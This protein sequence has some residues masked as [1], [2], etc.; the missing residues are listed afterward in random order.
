MEGKDFSNMKLASQVGVRDGLTLGEKDVP[1][2]QAQQAKATQDAKAAYKANDDAAFQEAYGRQVYLAGAMEGLLRKGPNYDLLQKQGPE[3]IPPLGG[4]KPKTVRLFNGGGTSWFTPDPERAASFGT[5]SYVD[6]PYDVFEKSQSAAK[7]ESGTSAD[8]VLPN[9]WVKQ[10]QPI[11]AAPMVHDLDAEEAPVGMGAAKLGEK[12]VTV[13]GT[14]DVYGIRQATRE[15]RAAAGKTTV[16]E[17][18]KGISTPDS[19]EKGR[20]IIAQNPTAAE[21]ALSNFENDPEHAVSAN[22]IA[23]TRAHGEELQ[24]IANQD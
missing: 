5:V 11:A 4:Q 17:P 19:L 23:A 12:S 16:V 21:T 10:S 7:K 14:P 24:L 3:I 2:L 1:E 20:Q 22:A 18:G 9:E 15:S 13:K 8:V 6:V